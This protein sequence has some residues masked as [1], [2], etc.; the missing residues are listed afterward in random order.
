MWGLVRAALRATG[1]AGGPLRVVTCRPMAASGPAAVARGS[2]NTAG[3]I[4]IGDEILKVR[5]GVGLGCGS[6]AGWGLRLR[7]RGI[8]S[9]ASLFPSGLH[10]GYKLLLHVP[11]TA[12]SRRDCRPDLG[13]AR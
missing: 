13:G 12:C 10:A 3:I 5:P 4:I 9:W 2:A 8:P 11:A 1:R 6:G 7:I